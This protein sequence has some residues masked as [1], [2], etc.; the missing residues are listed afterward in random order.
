M[1]TLLY[2]GVLV[3]GEYLVGG[4]E[5]IQPT[6]LEAN[7]KVTL[8]SWL[9]TLIG[10]FGVFAF[11]YA[12]AAVSNGKWMGGG[13]VKLVFLLGLFVG[14]PNIVVAVFLAFLLGS[15]I[16]VTQ[17]RLSKKKIS[18]EI[19][20]GPY[21]VTGTWISLFFG[22]ILVKFYLETILGF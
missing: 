15:I 16:G 19:P 20:F 3:L 21:L 17:M 10:A 1:I 6:F 18:H 9:L 14:W 5:A 7:G 8:S 22:D 4:I 13:D 12:I 11:F 2:L